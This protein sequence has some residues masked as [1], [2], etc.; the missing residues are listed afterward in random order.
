M[1][2]YQN[3]FSALAD[4]TRREIF[5]RLARRPAAGRGA[6]GGAA[7]LAARR[8]AAPQGAAD[9]GLVSDR[10]D[11]S[12]RLYRVNPRGVA[13][14]REYLD[15]FWSDALAA[16][17]TAARR[18]RK[19][20]K[21]MEAVTHSVLV[22]LDPDAAFELFTDRFADWWPKDSHHISDADAADVFLEP[23]EGG[24]WYERAEDGSECDWG[25]VK[26]IERPDRILLAW[27]LTPEWKFDPDPGE[28]HRGRG[29]LHAEENGTRVTL[30]HR[31]FEVHGEAGAGMRESV[32]SDG[33]WP[34]LLQLYRAAA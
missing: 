17:E 15:R 33:G 22:P 12:R 6:R 7:R 24:R 30:E 34:Q 13:G 27:Q 8:L 9:A 25:H 5:E 29:H 4:P 16:F 2:T 23:R 1:T 18:R 11:G 10:Q 26:E 14:M 19:M 21:T 28:G 3:G 20:T 31:G 32:S